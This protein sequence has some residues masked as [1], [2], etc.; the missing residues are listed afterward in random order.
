MSNTFRK[1]LMI[2][3]AL[4]ALVASPLSSFA[5]ASP[6]ASPVASNDS[7]QAGV[8]WLVSQQGADGAWI[9]FSG[10]ADVGVT[11]DA[12]LALVAAAETGVEVDLTSATTYLDANIEPYAETGPGQAAKAVLVA[13]ALGEDPE[14]FG[15]MNAWD[16]MLDGYDGSTDLYGFG[17]YDTGLVMLAYGA[18]GEEVPQIV[19][20]KVEELQLPDGAWAFDGNTLEGSGDTNTTSLMIQALVSLGMT[21]SDMVLH[22]IEYLQGS[23]LPQGFPFQSGAGAMPDANSTGITVQA[24][25][26]AGEDPADQEW[27]NVFGSLAT[28]QNPSGS[29]SY[30][31][32]PMDEN[33]FAT[34]QVLPALAG[35]AFPI[36]NGEEAPSLE[37]L[38]T[39]TA[40]QISATPVTDV[41]L[42]CAA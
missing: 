15:A 34:V 31:L 33:L 2:L 28:F 36:V 10:T 4:L 19:I 25:I 3:I 5:Q 37:L 17:I 41:E 14:K 35:I 7:L 11:I 38:P 40:D 9:G 21:D 12:V 39:C 18:R 6:E 26:A 8:D 20:S 42:Q 23:Q 32:D 30:M 29:F 13:L 24:L 22:G 27:Q 1:Y 16:E